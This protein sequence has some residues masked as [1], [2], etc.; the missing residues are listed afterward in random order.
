MF[1]LKKKELKHKWSEQQYND[2]VPSVKNKKC[3]R[4][5]IRDR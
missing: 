1:F 4:G 5:A 3:K 2:T